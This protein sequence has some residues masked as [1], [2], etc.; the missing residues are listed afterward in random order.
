MRSYLKLEAMHDVDLVADG[1]VTATVR[2]DVV[3]AVVGCCRAAAR[4]SGAGGSRWRSVDL[5]ERERRATEEELRGDVARGGERK[6][7]GSARR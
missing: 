5:G 1:G 7:G 2:P 6:V 3:C 4:A